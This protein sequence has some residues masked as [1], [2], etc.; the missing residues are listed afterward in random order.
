MR[1]EEAKAR[2]AQLL[3]DRIK[4]KGVNEMSLFN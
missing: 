2:D 3:V 1:Y 4:V